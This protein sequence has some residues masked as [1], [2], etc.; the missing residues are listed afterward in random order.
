[1]SDRHED[2]DHHCFR[3]DHILYREVLNSRRKAH[4]KHGENSIEAV[5]WH[6]PRWL[7][8]LVEEIGE[9]AHAL[10]Y[11]SGASLT[12]LRSELVDVLAVASAWA[13]KIGDELSAAP[14]EVPHV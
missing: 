6:D 13:D 2:N 3:G 11:D 9:V 14:L 4:E 12:D 5:T 7:S 10:T 8:I 1:M